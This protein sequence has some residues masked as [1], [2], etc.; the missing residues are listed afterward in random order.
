[1]SS[2]FDE[3]ERL[4]PLTGVWESL[5]PLPT[6]RH[7]L[8]AVAVGNRIYVLAGGPTPSGSAS[9]LNEVFIVLPKAGP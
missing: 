3:T 4:T 9:A 6:A 1:M 5:P 8:A 7:G 2:A